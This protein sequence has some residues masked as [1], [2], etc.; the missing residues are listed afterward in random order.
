MLQVQNKNCNLQRCLLRYGVKHVK[1][2]SFLNAIVS[3]YHLSLFASHAQEDKLLKD[4]DFDEFKKQICSAVTVDSFLTLQ[5]GELVDI[6][7]ETSSKVSSS[8]IEELQS[9]SVVLKATKSKET[10][11]FIVNAYNS[12]QKY[13]LSSKEIDYTYVW[14]I[15]TILTV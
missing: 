7:Y 4:H 13:M 2:Q 6:F 3:V 12:F 8:S 5:N 10:K 1:G 15:F 11:E 14:D 9:T